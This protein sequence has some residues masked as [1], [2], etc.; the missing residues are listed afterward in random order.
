M[1]DLKISHKDPEEVTV[2]IAY[3]ESIYGIMTVKSGKKHTYLGMDIDLSDIGKSKISMNCYIDEAVEE[4]PKD[5]S[6]PVSSPVYDHLFKTIK[7]K[8]LPEDQALLFHILV[9]K[10]LFV[11]KRARPDVQPTIYFIT[12][13]VREPN[14]ENWK[15]FANYYNT[16]MVP[17]ICASR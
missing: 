14:K 3:S 9:G 8:L 12:I 6:T 17:V 1:D 13:H 7:E 10:L 2:M 15:T 11:S 5:V 4:F 16:W